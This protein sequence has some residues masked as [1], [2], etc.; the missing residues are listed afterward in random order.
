[1]FHVPEQWRI[2][3]GKYATHK[4]D[5]NNGAFFIPNRAPKLLPP[6]RCLASDGMGWEHVSVSHP[7]R[8]PTWSEM[9]YVC[10]IFWDDDDCVMQ[11]HPPRVEWV[12][13]HPYTLHLW[14]PND[15]REIPRPDALLVGPVTA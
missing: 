13:C 5:G 1:M 2:K 15:G 9:E 11:L 6:L 7:D 3:V 10:R 4:T 14:R 8:C 12:N